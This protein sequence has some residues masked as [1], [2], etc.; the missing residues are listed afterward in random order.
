MKTWNRTYFYTTNQGR[1]TNFIHL[2]L[3][4]RLFSALAL[5]SSFSF[6]PLYSLQPQSSTPKQTLLNYLDVLTVSFPKVYSLNCAIFPTCR[7]VLNILHYYVSISWSRSQ[8]WIPSFR[9]TPKS[10][11]P[12]YFV[13][14]NILSYKPCFYNSSFSLHPKVSETKPRTHTTT[15]AP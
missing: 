6:E 4:L 5:A 14:V 12:I 11:Q 9:G 1:K 8:Q 3:L 13:L 15:L 10:H 7:K 2:S